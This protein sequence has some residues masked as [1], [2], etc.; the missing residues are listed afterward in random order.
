MRLPGGAAATERA[1]GR[2][3]PAGL[4]GRAGRLSG[5]PGERYDESTGRWQEL[6][7]RRAA[8]T[9]GLD[10]YGT[11]AAELQKAYDRMAEAFQWEGPPGLALREL[12]C[13]ET[14]FDRAVPLPQ[15]GDGGVS[16]I[17][18]RRS[19]RGRHLPGLCCERRGTSMS[20]TNHERPGVYSRYDAST[21]VKAAAA[22]GG[23]GGP[24]RHRNGGNAL[25]L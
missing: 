9:F 15:G 13:G 5:L 21:V 24:V 2:R 25:H 1:G 7:G 3:I 12:S 8:L 20:V 4:S 10:L 6:Y 11:S 19:R 14:E 16:G 18:V 17:P 22:A 23:T